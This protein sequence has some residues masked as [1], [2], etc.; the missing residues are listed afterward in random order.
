MV[1]G[2]LLEEDEQ[3][4]ASQ[5]VEVQEMWAQGSVVSILSEDIWSV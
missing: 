5:E 1:Q 2:M 3:Q 4:D